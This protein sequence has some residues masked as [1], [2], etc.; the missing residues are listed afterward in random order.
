MASSKEST[1]SAAY[2]AL[3]ASSAKGGVLKA[4]GEHS[5]S[6]YFATPIADPFGD[7]TQSFF[8]HADGAGTK[9][10][11]AYL[12]Y[13]ETGDTKWFRSLA[14]DSLVMN[15]DD[16]ACSGALSGLVLSNTIGR[17]RRLVPDEAIS[18]IIAGYKECAATLNSF[19][20]EIT[21]SGGETADMGDLVRTL[22]VDSTL[23]ARIPSD[24]LVDTYR[25]EPG[26]AI[27][28]F[29]NVGQVAWETAPNSG[30]GSNGLSLARNVLLSRY[31]VERYPEAGDPEIPHDVAY[32]GPY[33]ASDFVAEL[34][35]SVGAALLSPTRSYAPLIK[36]AL[37]ELRTAIHSLIHCTGGGQVKIKRFGRGVRFEKTDLFPI[38]PLFDLIQRHGAIPW[39][40]M[41][42]VFNMGHRLEAC[43]DP[44]A[45]SEII[46]LAAQFGIAA[47]IIGR[48]SST[49]GENEVVIAS[50][51]GEF[52]Y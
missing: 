21:L 46:A 6:R 5:T 26:D 50:P 38:P 1:E 43:I 29:S 15:L 47:R 31:H 41:Y 9:S 19:G 36:T 44:A 49:G 27:V 32:R 25:V 30:I 13:R 34:G 8:L 51:H 45:S 17:N 22:V 48:V 39:P 16:I 23:S 24:E 33:K 35:T 28:A 7:P 4:V 18:E 12:L 2:A 40:E 37:R 20:I 11:V 14:T 52:T 3:G 42:S 10:I